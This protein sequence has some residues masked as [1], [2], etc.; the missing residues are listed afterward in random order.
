MMKKIHSYKI[1]QIHRNVL[2]A[3]LSFDF[4]LRRVIARFVHILHHEFRRELK[5]TEE[6]TFKIY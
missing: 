4:D 5:R 2:F 1:K 6:K 3:L